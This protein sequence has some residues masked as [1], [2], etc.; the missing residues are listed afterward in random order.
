MTLALLKPMCRERGL[1]VGGSKGEIVTRLHRHGLGGGNGEA[2]GAAGERAASAGEQAAHQHSS[3]STTS[4]LTM[5]DLV[6]E[7]MTARWLG[8]RAA[9]RSRGLSPTEC[10]PTYDRIRV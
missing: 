8:L 6:R 2:G 9:A 3:F 1:K 7:A 10:G 4:R 5:E